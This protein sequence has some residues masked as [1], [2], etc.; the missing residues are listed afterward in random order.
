MK[1]F[2]VHPIEYYNLCGLMN[3]IENIMITARDNDIR[4]L[5]KKTLKNLRILKKMIEDQGNKK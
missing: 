2:A 1:N 3:C 4:E 5:A